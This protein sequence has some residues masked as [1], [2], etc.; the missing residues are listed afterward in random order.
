MSSQFIACRKKLEMF[1]RYKFGWM[2]HLQYFQG[3]LFCTDYVQ[4]ENGSEI[5]AQG[6]NGYHRAQTLDLSQGRCLDLAFLWT[7]TK[8]WM[9]WDAEGPGRC[10]ASP[11]W[12]Q[13]HSQYQAHSGAV[14]F[15]KVA[16]NSTWGRWGWWWCMCVLGRTHQFIL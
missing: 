9:F 1:W 7:L 13:G 15:G 3:Q 16:T 12:S 11:A 6:T 2:T 10:W 14:A 8:H 5:L 4:G